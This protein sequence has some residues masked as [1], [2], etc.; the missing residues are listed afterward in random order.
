[1]D[2][3]TL[4]SSACISVGPGAMPREGAGGVGCA[5]PAAGGSL[6]APEGCAGWG[7][8]PGA[9]EMVPQ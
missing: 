9:P 1:M 2:R 7:L 3:V 8:L 4:V 5:V 6:G